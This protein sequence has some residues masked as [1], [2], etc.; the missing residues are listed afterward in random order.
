MNRQVNLT[1]RLRLDDGSIRYY[2]VPLFN[3]GNPKPNTIIVGGKEEQ[4]E[5]GV[6]VIDWTEGNPKGKDRRRRKAV[7]K[8]PKNAA[9]ERRK[10]EA[11]LN[12]NAEG[13]AV[14][15]DKE[16]GGVTLAD[17]IADYLAETQASKKKKTLAAY[18][19]ALTSFQA[20]CNK[21]LLGEVTRRDLLNFRQ[22]LADG[23]KD[24]KP[25]GERTVRNKFEFVIIFLKAVK[26]LAA[27]ELVKGDRPP[28]LEKKVVIYEREELERLFAAC[29]DTE[30]TW[31]DF[32]LM[33]GL[34]E[35][36]VQHTYWDDVNLKQRTVTVTHK[37][38]RGWMPKAYKE[39]DVPIPQKLVDRLR[40]FKGDR[41]PGCELLFPTRGCNVKLDFLDCLKAVARRAKLNPNKFKLHKFRATY[42]T[43]SLRAG[44]DLRTVQS[45]LGHSDLESTMRYLKPEHSQSVRAA[46]DRTWDEPAA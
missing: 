29:S 21:R 8:D 40:E 25:V 12:A 19:A 3:N 6:Y 28:K 37:P 18:R 20:S 31:F 27:L 1:M 11:I 26:H 15:A 23:T 34:R 10:Q 2:P 5:R 45:W 43:W 14:V 42:A 33:T 44:N 30:R 46:V 16:V 22:W 36:E 9:R 7:G 39:R 38:D 41:E 32:F 4:R 13:I 35:Q 24:R 17:T